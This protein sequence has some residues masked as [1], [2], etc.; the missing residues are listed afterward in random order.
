MT[1]SLRARAALLGMQGRHWNALRAFRPCFDRHEAAIGSALAAAAASL[2]PAGDRAGGGEKAAGLPALRDAQTAAWR[3]LLDGDL[4]EAARRVL[5]LADLL[6]RMGVEVVGYTGAY[7][8]ALNQ[9][10]WIAVQD[11]CRKP[12]VLADL[13]QALSLMGSLDRGFLMAIFQGRARAA[14]RRRLQEVAAELEATVSG[15]LE[16]QVQATATLRTT[17]EAMSATATQ[18]NACARDAAQATVAAADSVTTVLAAIQQ[19]A[20]STESISGLVRQSGGLVGMAVQHARATDDAIGVL[21]DR[22]ADIEQILRLISAISSRTN[23]LALNASIEAARAGDAGRGFAVV[24]AEVKQL[25]RQTAAAT[26]EIAAQI[27]SIQG[28]TGTAV[29]ANRQIGGTVREITGIVGAIAAAIEQQDA[30]AR[31]IGAAAGTAAG[32]VVTMERSID[33]V[34]AAAGHT[35][36]AAHAIRLEA[37]QLTRQADALSRSIHVFLERI[38]A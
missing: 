36:Q 14:G 17:A 28:L 23:L 6:E 25:A 4:D 34:A 10:L 33:E 22:A 15:L 38:H 19:L 8:Q 29:G 5:A 1:D 24:A 12:A 21:A 35:D 11:F 27:H 30:A 26:E 16:G 9:M 31:A 37:G 18:T 13:V 20:G 3:C 32:C 2:Q 7:G